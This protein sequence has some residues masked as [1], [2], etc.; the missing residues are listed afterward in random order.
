[1][2]NY[3]NNPDKFSFTL[4]LDINE[5][6]I[7]SNDRNHATWVFLSLIFQN[8]SYARARRAQVTSE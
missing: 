4:Y 8:V 3:R 1:M 5:F 7:A 2:V 6:N